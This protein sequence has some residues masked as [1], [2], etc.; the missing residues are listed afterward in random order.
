MTVMWIKGLSG[1]GRKTTSNHARISE[2]DIAF[3]RLGLGNGTLPF[4]TSQKR[5]K[6]LLGF[7]SGRKTTKKRKTNGK[8]KRKPS[9]YCLIGLSQGVAYSSG[10]NIA[11]KTRIM[12]TNMTGKKTKRTQTT[13]PTSL[14]EFSSLAFL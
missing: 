10:T 12:Y 14:H 4:K 1:S 7:W 5:P 11:L 8:K 3:P 13:L 6:S 2:T 9:Q